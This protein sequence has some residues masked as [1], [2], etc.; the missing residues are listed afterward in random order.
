M[1]EDLERNSHGLNSYI[2]NIDFFQDKES[3]YYSGLF[4]KETHINVAHQKGSGSKAEYNP[5]SSDA[6]PSA[7]FI[8]DLLK[9]R[10]YWFH[11]KG[12]T[13]AP[14]A[15]SF[16]SFIKRK[17]YKPIA[18]TYIEEIKL[19]YQRMPKG[20]KSESF[21]EFKRRRML[22][23]NITRNRFNIATVPVIDE[24]NISQAILDK[25]YLIRLV[26]VKSYIPN[27]TK[28]D[29]KDLQTWRDPFE[30]VSKRAKQELGAT[31]KTEFKGINGGI[32]EEK[33]E[34][35]K[36]VRELSEKN[37]YDL[38]VTMTHKTD[39]KKKKVVH[40]S[41]KDEYTDM[42]F[43]KIFEGTLGKVKDLYIKVK[44]VDTNV[45]NSKIPD[46]EMREAEEII[47]DLI[48]IGQVKFKK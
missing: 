33:E 31:V 23:L 48:E 18:H 43:R 6:Y 34:V 44:D 14:Q 3:Y 41:P 17:V 21:S 11:V 7:Y 20:A 36:L 32:L 42:G 2:G 47:D 9:H 30:E 46:K 22:E 38:S 10:L 5:L 15:S 4:F 1:D 13:H 16:A 24:K 35:L 25:D 29:G 40:S 19:E 45:L 27:S 28:N 26:T 39:P 37:N 8:I 12:E